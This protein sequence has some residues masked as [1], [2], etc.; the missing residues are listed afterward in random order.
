MTYS[1]S[2]RETEPWLTSCPGSASNFPAQKYFGGKKKKKISLVH[3]MGWP[4]S[5]LLHAPRW[6]PLSVVAEGSQDQGASNI[7]SLSLL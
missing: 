7:L 3:F 4:R 2:Q 5:Q 1:A 6:S